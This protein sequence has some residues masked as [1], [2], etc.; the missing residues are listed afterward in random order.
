[1]YQAIFLSIEILPSLRQSAW[2]IVIVGCVLLALGILIGYLLGNTS[3][4]KY[5]EKELDDYEHQGSVQKSITDNVG[6]GIIVYNQTGPVY[7][8]KTLAE[9]KGFLNGGVPKS[10][11]IFLDTYDKGNHLKSDYIL[12]TENGADT[13]RADYINNNRVYEIKI[14]KKEIIYAKRDKSETEVTESFHII[15]IE[16]VTLVKERERRQKDLAANVSHEL[17]TPLT[18]IRASE[19]IVEKINR[20]GM[21]T[22][23]E[24]K[25][26]AN[27]ILTNAIR[28]QDIVEDFLVLSNNSEMKKMGIFDFSLIVEK[29]IANI[30]DHP[31]ASKVKIIPPKNDAYPLGFGNNKLI[32]RIVTNLLTNAV[33]YID[34]DGK[35]EPHEVK[36]NIVSTPDNVGIQVADNGRGIPAKDIDHLFE[37]F[38]RVDNSGSREV[39]GSGL[40]LAIAKEMAEIHDGNINVVSTVGEGSTFTLFLPKAQ[41]AFERVYEDAKTGVISEIEYYNAVMRFL[42]LEE[43]E[44]AKS[45]NFQE[46]V[47]AMDELAIESDISDIADT[48]KVKILTLLGDERFKELVDDLTYVEVF[49]DEDDYEDYDEEIFEDEVEYQEP[50]EAEFEAKAEEY[51]NEVLEMME[52]NRLALEEELRKEE[53]QRIQEELERQKK[54]E[55]QELLMQPVIQQ[56][57]KQNVNTEKNQTTLTE[58]VKP[59]QKPAEKSVNESKDTVHIHPNTDKKGYN[60]K[61]VKLFASKSKAKEPAKT[62][63]KKAEPVANTTEQH[64]EPIRSAVRQVLDAA[65]VD[66][67]LIKNS[68][69]EGNN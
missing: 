40:G 20:G 28:M 8:N 24:L 64:V 57:I 16:D 35:T 52:A 15:L 50:S 31:A 32:I 12:S 25:N 30:K 51:S 36:V 69:T 18:V 46:I 42:L 59:A 41:T 48:D 26:W 19:N 2:L 56:S 7:A 38:Y 5:Y 65:E 53:E 37:R 23:E 62:P 63:V 47:A 55:A 45:R 6:L 34:F 68:D 17:K 3:L 11:D 27:R 10:L 14:I 1:M 39:G 43:N 54:K 67:K 58:L 13:V 22:P 21:L 44:L 33:K 61:G 4:R 29:S 49:D 66:N 60:G 9:L